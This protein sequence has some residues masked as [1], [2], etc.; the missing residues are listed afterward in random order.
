MMQI[1]CFHRFPLPDRLAFKSGLR[2]VYLACITTFTV[3]GQPPT[4]LSSNGMIWA[5]ANSVPIKIK[6]CLHGFSTG[7]KIL[8]PHT[9][10]LLIIDIYR[11]KSLIVLRWSPMCPLRRKS[12][13][14]T[15]NS[16]DSKQIL[17]CHLHLQL[18][19]WEFKHN[20]FACELLVD[21]REG[22]HLNQER[23]KSTL[24]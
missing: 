16:S 9:D 6:S 11:L 4:L 12:K 2:S 17:F 19:F 21:T 3:F 22:L 23:I 8:L 7:L 1:L 13:T 24:V 14:T 10:R 20:V 18:E 5:F 15:C